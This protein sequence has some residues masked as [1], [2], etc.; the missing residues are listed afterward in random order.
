[1]PIAVIVGE[2]AC[3]QQLTGNLPACRRKLL[4]MKAAILRTFL[5]LMCMRAA[6]DS[7]A[8][9]AP[10]LQGRIQETRMRGHWID[11]STGL[12]W[13][14]KDN[15]K[16]LSWKEAKKYCRNLRLDSYSDWRLANMAELQ[17][18]YDSSA[19]AP[20]LAGPP[21]EQRT[22]TFHV[23]GNLF[24]TGDQ[25]TNN[26]RMDDRGRFSGY[27]YYFDFNSG[28]PDENPTG[29]LEPFTN[30]HALCVRGPGK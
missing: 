11:P 26:Y 13:A 21:K 29:F 6:F 15:G 20:G 2:I 7:S 12:M 17:G 23:K 3:L 28:K 5:L 19:N 25:W 24:L 22:F 14:V 30:M 4:A 10:E 1:M 27:V 16:D 8:Q 9:S 18:I